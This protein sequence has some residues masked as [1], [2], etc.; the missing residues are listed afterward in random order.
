MSTLVQLRMGLGRA[1]T[2]DLRVQIEKCVN[3]LAQLFFNVF[4]RPLNDVQRDPGLT[5]I[6]ELDRGL[7]YLFN[8]V[9]GQ[10]AQSVNQ[11]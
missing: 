11:S 1:V 6:L 5:A 4:L 8:L 7:S 9:R 2:S 3:T 10:Q